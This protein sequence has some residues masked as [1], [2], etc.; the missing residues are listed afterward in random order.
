MEIKNLIKEKIVDVFHGN[1]SVEWWIES[2]ESI[3]F[4]RKKMNQGKSSLP[5]GKLE[6]KEVGLLK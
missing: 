6:N 3:R 5:S 2:T 1:N 4:K